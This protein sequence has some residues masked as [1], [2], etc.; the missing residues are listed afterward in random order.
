MQSFFSSRHIGHIPIGIY[1]LLSMEQWQEFAAKEKAQ[2]AKKAKA[3]L[4][5]SL[6]LQEPASRQAPFS[7]AEAGEVGAEVRSP[8]S[9]ESS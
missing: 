4:T 6:F 5:S 9:W 8:L 7:W 2:T 1:H 3:A